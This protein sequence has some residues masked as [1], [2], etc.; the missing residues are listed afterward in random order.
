MNFDSVDATTTGLLLLFLSLAA[1]MGWAAGGSA[2]R[3]SA[4]GGECGGVCAWGCRELVLG[5]LD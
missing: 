3:A 4:A 2:R 5:I 1:D